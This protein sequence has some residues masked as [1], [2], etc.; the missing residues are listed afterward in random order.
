MVFFIWSTSRTETEIFKILQWHETMKKTVLFENVNKSE[1]LIQ[2]SWSTFYYDKK[3]KK[4][5]FQ[6]F[7]HYPTESLHVTHVK[8]KMSMP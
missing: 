3:K 4:K 8:V 5:A 1:I 7:L 6:T 2:H